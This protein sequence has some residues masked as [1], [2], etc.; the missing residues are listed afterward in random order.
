MADADAFPSYRSCVFFLLKRSVRRE[1]RAKMMPMMEKLFQ[2]T[3]TRPNQKQRQKHK[4]THT[5]TPDEI[6]E[7]LFNG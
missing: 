1:A 5:H 2:Y 3:F 6:K 4:D 7:E